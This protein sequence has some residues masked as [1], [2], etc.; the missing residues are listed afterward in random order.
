MSMVAGHVVHFL[1]C[2]L[3]SFDPSGWFISS[4]VNGSEI[5]RGKHPQHIQGADSFLDTDVHT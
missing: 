1:T 2:R 4:Q 3:L 5:I